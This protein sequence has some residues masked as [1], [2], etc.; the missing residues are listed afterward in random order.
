MEGQASAS[1]GGS[2]VGAKSAEGQVSVSMGGSAMSARSAEVPASVS[3][4][5]SAIAA[6]SA[7]VSRTVAKQLVNHGVCA[8]TVVAFK[9]NKFM[10]E[11][12]DG[13][14]A[15]VTKTA[16]KKKLSPVLA[17]VTAMATEGGGTRPA[18]TIL[19]QD[20]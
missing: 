17:D 11:Y 10:I 7:Q 8:G 16:L 20:F 3:T 4:G 19:V 2:A 12:T 14:T 18:A 5:G 6:S 9:S 13:T 1:T 15:M